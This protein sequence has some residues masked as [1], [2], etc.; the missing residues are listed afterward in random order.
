MK[1]IQ[2]SIQ[3]NKADELCSYLFKTRDLVHFAH[4]RTS[5]YASHVALNDL[6]EDILEFADSLTE[7][8]QGI[9][10]RILVL[11]VC[12]SSQDIEDPIIHLKG[13][14]QYLT[15]IK[16]TF[17]SDIINII[18]ELIGKFNETLYK[19]QFLH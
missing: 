2:R 12:A 6:Y 14:V 15:S 13:C 7:K 17:T 11:S 3:T 9:E 18:E 16:Q 5:S 10:G 19:L 8:L 4:L 1:T